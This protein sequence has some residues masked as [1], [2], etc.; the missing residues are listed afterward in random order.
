MLRRLLLLLLA[1]MLPLQALAGATNCGH[2]PRSQGS[3][4]TGAAADQAAQ[5]TAMH[6][7]Q[8]DTAQ[9]GKGATN[10]PCDHCG[11]CQLAHGAPLPAARANFGADAIFDLTAGEPRSPPGYIPDQPLR[12]PRRA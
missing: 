10:P 2:W 12:P 8:A 5:V 9:A 4:A 6:C 11:Y 3:G 1:L 7:D